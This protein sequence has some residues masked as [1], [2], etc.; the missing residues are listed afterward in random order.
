MDF[1]FKDRFEMLETLNNFKPYRKI[2]YQS[3]LPM[4]K[5]EVN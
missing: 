4:L 1:A 3:E 2:N 5:S